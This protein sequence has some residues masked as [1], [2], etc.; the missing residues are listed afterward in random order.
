MIVNIGTYFKSL[1]CPIFNTNF[2]AFNVKIDNLFDLY[3]NNFSS[4]DCINDLSCI[5]VDLFNVDITFLCNDFYNFNVFSNSKGF[6][7]SSTIV[8]SIE[9]GLSRRK[10]KRREFAD[11]QF[12]R[13]RCLAVREIF[14]GRNEISGIDVNN[15]IEF[16]CK[17]VMNKEDLGYN[18]GLEFDRVTDSDIAFWSPVTLEELHK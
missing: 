8:K 7:P 4:S 6:K 13:N 18:P 17:V 3:Y 11:F 16:W 12:K 14:E 1:S 5:I 15:F 9:L 2:N 10:L